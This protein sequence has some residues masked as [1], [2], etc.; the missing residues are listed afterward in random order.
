MLTLFDKACA[1]EQDEVDERK[2]DAGEHQLLV[3]HIYWPF[4]FVL[5]LPYIV[6]IL[7]VVGENVQETVSSTRSPYG[8]PWIYVVNKYLKA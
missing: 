6:S 8:D 4:G 7:L 2:E 5:P 1:A 3:G